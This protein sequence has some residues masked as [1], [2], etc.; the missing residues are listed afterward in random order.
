MKCNDLRLHAT[1]NSSQ[2]LAWRVVLAFPGSSPILRFLSDTFQSLSFYRE[3][4]EQSCIHGRPCS[5]GLRMNRKVDIEDICV[6]LEAEASFGNVEDSNTAH[7]GWAEQSERHH[8][9]LGLE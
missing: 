3:E 9:F 2:A 5:L 8:I 4:P 1:S 6:V 7:N